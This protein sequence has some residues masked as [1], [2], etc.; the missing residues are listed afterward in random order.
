[1]ENRFEM[2]SLEIADVDH[3]MTW[4]NDPE[5]V[6]N[7]QHFDKT[8]TREDE[9]SYINKILSSKNDFVF[10]FFDGSEYI[11][12]GGIHQISWENK[13][14]RVSIMIARKH[15]GKGYG[16]E[17]LKRLINHAFKELGLHKIWLMHWKENKKAEHIYKKLGFKKEGILKDEYYWQGQYHDMVRMAII[18]EKDI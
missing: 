13:L 2:K 5:V 14:G 7:L 6:K 16:Q 12:Q 11:G 9:L 15:W 10:S 3:I 18:N 8:L 4:V 1:M 17:I